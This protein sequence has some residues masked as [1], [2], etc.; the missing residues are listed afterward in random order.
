MKE[1]RILVVDDDWQ[2]RRLLQLIFTRAGYDVIEAQNG[3]EALRL[4]DADLPHLIIL[5]VMM[6]GID[7]FTTLNE[8]RA[9]HCPSH[10]PVLMLSGR[11]DVAAKSQG[12][13]AGA[14]DYI[15]KP[16]QAANLLQRVSHFL[17]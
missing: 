13:E 5:D 2:T 6:P 10:L 15:V 17:V 4:L 9:M 16:F 12:Q 11:A 1:I 3:E 7:G 8:I 14:Q